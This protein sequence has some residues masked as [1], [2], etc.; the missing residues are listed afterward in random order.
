MMHGVWQ[1]SR[2]EEQSSSFCV[3][4]G[5]ILGG[6]DYAAS[7]GATRTLSNH[8]LSYAR[9]HMVAVAAAYRLQAIDIVSIHY[10]DLPRC[11]AEA[12]EGKHHL[13]WLCIYMRS[14]FLK[15]AGMLTI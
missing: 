9:Q 10:K 11:E 15:V 12:R 2:N 4:D 14:V 5:V 3:H 7:V 13:D 8:E 6:D 1:M